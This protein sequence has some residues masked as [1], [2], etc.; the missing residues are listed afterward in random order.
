MKSL[1]LLLFIAGLMF[2]IIG[3]MENYK[4]CPLPKIEYRYIPR[5]FYEEQIEQQNLKNTYSDM[6][7]KSDTW[8]RYPLGNNNVNSNNI[9]NYIQEYTNI[10]I[11]ESDYDSE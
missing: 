9:E 7:N 4:N 6:F 11:D 2:I 5:N 10:N 8:A 3:Y 1:I